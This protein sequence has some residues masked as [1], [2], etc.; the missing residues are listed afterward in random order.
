MKSYKYIKSFSPTQNVS[1]TAVV[2]Q[3]THPSGTTIH[4][5]SPIIAPLE[6]VSVKTHCNGCNN[7]IYTR[8]ND[9]VS[10]DGMCW[11]ILCCVSGNWILGL[12]VLCLDG[13]NVY[14]H[15]CPACNRFIGEYRPEMSGGAIALLFFLTILI[16]GFMFICTYIIYISIYSIFYT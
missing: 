7:E 6:K 1:H 2:Y 3:P 4:L 11:A 8:V 10:E 14:R 16:V 9:E 13:S 12:L 5:Y 15:F